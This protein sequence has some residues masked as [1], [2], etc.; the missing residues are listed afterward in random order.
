MTIQLGQNTFLLRHYTVYACTK[1]RSFVE[2]LFFAVCFYMYTYFSE[3]LCLVVLF[4]LLNSFFIDSSFNCL[5]HHDHYA[6][7][8]LN[9]NSKYQ[10]FYNLFSITKQNILTV[11]IHIYIEKKMFIHISLHS[12]IVIHMYFSHVYNETIIGA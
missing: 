1:S 6:M 12:F 3:E 8:L 10:S 7:A 4:G 9:I 11:N 5:Y 2:L